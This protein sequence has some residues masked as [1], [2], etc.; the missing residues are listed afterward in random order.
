MLIPLLKSIIL[1][2]SCNDVFVHLNTACPNGTYGTRCSR[3]CPRNYYGQ[4]CKGYCKCNNTYCDPA[5]GACSDIHGRGKWLIQLQ[6]ADTVVHTRHRSQCAL[7][8]VDV[9][10]TRTHESR[11]F[12]L[13]KKLFLCQI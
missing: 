3:R 11:F 9:L 4:F 10:S 6:F 5:T 8:F 1:N 12:F 2:Y 13:K 7:C